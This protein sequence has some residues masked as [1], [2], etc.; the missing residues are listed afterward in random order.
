[1]LMLRQ[2]AL[3]NS[4]DFDRQPPDLKKQELVK[5]YSKRANATKDLQ[6]AMEVIPR[7]DGSVQRR[8]QRWPHVNF[9]LFS[10]N[11]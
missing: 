2:L 6:E 7:L 8:T 10:V 11:T 9:R 5:R 1:M 3:L 4:Y